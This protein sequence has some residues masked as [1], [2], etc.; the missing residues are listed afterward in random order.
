MLTFLP[1]LILRHRKENVKKCSLRGLE[2]REDFRFF[3]YPCSE[4]PDVRGYCLLTI[5]APPISSAD[6]HL[7]LFLIDATWRYAKAMEAQI[8]KTLSFERRSLPAHFRTAYPRYQTACD[9][10]ERGLASIEALYIAFLLTER[11]VDSLLDG[12]YWKD[13]FLA[14]NNLNKTL[15]QKFEKDK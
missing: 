10:P 5:D 3:S 13:E 12:Y 11:S 15:D 7:G 1:T 2:K 6:Q 8:P 9:D 14:R 4:W